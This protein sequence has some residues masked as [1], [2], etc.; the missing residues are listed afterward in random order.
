MSGLLQHLNIFTKLLLRIDQKTYSYEIIISSCFPTLSC[1]SCR[2]LPKVTT[3]LWR[4]RMLH[5]NCNNMPAWSRYLE[6]IY[7]YYLV[8]ITGP[9]NGFYTVSQNVTS[10]QLYFV[11]PKNTL[12]HSGLAEAKPERSRVIFGV[13]KIKL[14]LN[15]FEVP[16]VSGQYLAA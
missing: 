9:D 10:V 11:H 4:K 3:F 6:Q 14:H 2:N 13:Y 16:W 15:T 12:E 1:F 7:I 8:F 5:Q